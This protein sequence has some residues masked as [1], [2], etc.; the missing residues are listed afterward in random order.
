MDILAKE[1][2]QV[3]RRMVNEAQRQENFE[4]ED[5]ANSESNSL[6]GD[7][8][9]WD[10]REFVEEEEVAYDSP[11]DDLGYASLFMDHL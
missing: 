6:N 7:E 4:E 1:T 11:F 2:L 8:L 10:E 9:S 3:I 5:T